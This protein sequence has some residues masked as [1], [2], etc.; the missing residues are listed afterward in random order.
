MAAAVCFD[1]EQ[2]DPGVLWEVGCRMWIVT[3]VDHVET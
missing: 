2:V 3:P 1:Q